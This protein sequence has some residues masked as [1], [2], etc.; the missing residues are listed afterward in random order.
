[1]YPVN[2]LFCCQGDYP[3]L[4]FC[5]HVTC[6]DFS[7]IVMTWR[8]GPLSPLPIHRKFGDFFETIQIL[9][10]FMRPAGGDQTMS[11]QT[12]KQI[13]HVNIRIPLIQNSFNLVVIFFKFKVE[14]RRKMYK[15]KNKVAILVTDLRR[16]IF[17][18]FAYHLS[19]KV[20]TFEPKN[21][22]EIKFV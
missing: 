1:M 19:K 9:P 14:R 11:V 4:C 15:K 18:S 17:N 8:C 6:F 5:C 22:F 10:F 3:V 13:N 2:R 20:I 7:L 12:W 21:L 16:C